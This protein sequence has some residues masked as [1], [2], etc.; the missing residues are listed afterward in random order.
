VGIN[1]STRKQLKGSL[2]GSTILS[3]GPSEL[4]KTRC[5]RPTWAQEWD[6]MKLWFLLTFKFSKW[7]MKTPSHIL[8]IWRTLVSHKILN[9]SDLHDRL[10]LVTHLTLQSVCFSSS[11]PNSKLVSFVEICCITCCYQ[12]HTQTSA[13]SGLKETTTFLELS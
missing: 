8:S 3:Q 12:C 2:Q 1:L 6:G 11:S 13:L 7:F 5:Q 4:K 9:V 10:A